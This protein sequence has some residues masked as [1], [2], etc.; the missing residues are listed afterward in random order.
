MVR[1]VKK[2]A[3]R[4]S[5]IVNAAHHLFQV[6]GY[7]KTTMQDVMDHLVIAKGTIYHY[8]KS[9]EELLEAV[10]ENVVDEN[11]EE[12]Q[13]LMRKT[14]GNALEKIRMLIG[15]GNMAASHDEIMEHLHQP[16]NMGM[17]IRLLAATL[18][19]QAP[20]YAELIRQGCEEGIFQ[21]D[22]PLECAE[23]ILCAIQFLTDQGVYP[24]TQEQ[25]IRRAQA[26]PGLVEAQLK[27][28]S[29]SFQFMLSQT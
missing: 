21:T 12:L 10:I 25:L 1:V 29:G 28:A 5:E 22:T 9:K 24:W 20:L 17:H 18:V 27:A 6:K 3:E 19:K 4:K 8:F 2:A 14:D 26:F 23:F 13:T 11:I 7:D 16:G 15:A